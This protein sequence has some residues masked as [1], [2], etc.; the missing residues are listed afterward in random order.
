VTTLE[1]L[2]RPVHFSP[3]RLTH[4]N[5]FVK[6]VEQSLAFYNG[7]C[8]LEIVLRQPMI[9]A[10]FVSN[11]NTHH[12]IGM[13]QCTPGEL[14]G[15][16][17]HRI[18]AKGQGAH[19]GLNH[20]GWEM[21]S[22]FDLAKAHKRALAAGWK[23]HRTVRH[24][25]SHSVYVFDPDGNVHEFYADTV[26]DWR[27]NYDKAHKGASGQWNPGEGPPSMAPAYH[28]NPPI[29][30]VDT[31]PLHPLRTTHAV[32]L[33]RNFERMRLFMTEGA[34]LHEAS[35]DD[36]AGLATYAAPAAR[37]PV[38]LALVRTPEGAAPAAR[39]LHHVSF[40][41]ASDDEVAGGVQRL[42]KAGVK[43]EREVDAPHKKS[44][45]IRDPNG[46]MLEF[47]SARGVKNEAS[48][49][50]LTDAYLL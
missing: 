7:V 18:L 35:F 1:A 22:E 5:L 24:K 27:G 12:D 10:G 44:L 34:G 46:V 42:A 13:I 47:Y 8:G 43:V 9:N 38:T 23:I 33:A 20:I 30:R 36:K 16:G 32:L 11:G 25:S 48:R 14:Y 37:Y 15:E 4:A 6:D 49:N 31:A 45:F 2:S 21:E 41:M 40:E 19:P 3:R 50:G 28:L 29:R 17:G 39:G 26:A